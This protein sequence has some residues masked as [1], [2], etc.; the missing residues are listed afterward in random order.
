MGLVV[1]NNCGLRFLPWWGLRLIANVVIAIVVVAIIAAVFVV[2]VG[3]HPFV[4]GSEPLGIDRCGKGVCLPV[5]IAKPEYRVCGLH[6][7]AI[8]LT[9]FLG[10][11]SPCVRGDSALVDPSPY[12]PCMFSHTRCHATIYRSPVSIFNIEHHDVFALRRPCTTT[13]TSLGFDLGSIFP[14]D[15][16]VFPR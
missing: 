6:L 15:S 5:V 7:P 11:L 13:S 16:N 12:G 3:I 10:R 2:W 4:V 14:S 8:H 9:Y 1:N